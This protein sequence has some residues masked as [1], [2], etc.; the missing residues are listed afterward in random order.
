MFNPAFPV[1]YDVLIKARRLKLNK[2]PA[3]AHESPVLNI[4]KQTD[5]LKQKYLSRLGIGYP[6]REDE[7]YSI[8]SMDQGMQGGHEVPLS[9]FMNAQY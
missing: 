7:E 2:L 4:A 9:D 8:L 5:L 6:A 1:L 3:P